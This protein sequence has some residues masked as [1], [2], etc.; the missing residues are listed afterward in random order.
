MHDTTLDDENASQHVK[1]IVVMVL[2]N[3]PKAF[4]SDLGDDQSTL[5]VTLQDI[6]YYE[7]TVN[8]LVCNG[9]WCT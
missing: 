7:G 1:S 3:Q 5:L 2:C 6:T 8:H 9:E 4:A